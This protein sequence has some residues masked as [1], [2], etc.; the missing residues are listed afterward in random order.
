ME[1]CEQISVL[2]DKWHE[3]VCQV[4]RLLSP[5]R[6]DF[7]SSLVLLGARY[8]WVLLLQELKAAS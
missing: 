5:G 4:S 8:S 6:L 3:L 7:L 1:A 2:T